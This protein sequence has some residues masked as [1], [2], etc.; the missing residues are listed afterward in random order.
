MKLETYN[1]H[2]FGTYTVLDDKLEWV[3]R[4][5]VEGML[6]FTGVRSVWLG[7]QSMGSTPSMGNAALTGV[8]DGTVLRTIPGK[9]PASMGDGEGLWSMKI[10][11]DDQI[12]TIYYN[13]ATQDDKATFTRF[14]RALHKNIAKANPSASYI[15][16]G[17][18]NLLVFIFLSIVLLVLGGGAAFFGKATGLSFLIILGGVL[19]FAAL[20]LLIWGVRT[21]KPKAYDPNNIPDNLLPDQ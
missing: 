11:G 16:G 1:N 12:V 8:M 7:E 19:A 21:T 2:D 3:D 6:G 15:G 10:R 13:P 14:V 18:L 9:P 20:A 5:G 4:A 17:V